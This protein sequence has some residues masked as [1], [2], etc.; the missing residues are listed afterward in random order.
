[1][2]YVNLPLAMEESFWFG[3]PYLVTNAGDSRKFVRDGHN[4]FLE[5]AT[6][7][8]LMAEA[9]ERPRQQTAQVCELGR[10]AA[11]KILTFLPEDPITT[12]SGHI[13]SIIQR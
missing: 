10:T 1:M 4:R 11:L 7:G 8:L 3:R 5:R 6:P 9:L 2:R 13:L 12:A